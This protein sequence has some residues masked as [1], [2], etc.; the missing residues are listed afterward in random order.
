MN[1][2][3]RGLIGAVEKA[4]AREI[5]PNMRKMLFDLSEQIVDGFPFRILA[6]GTLARDPG[7]AVLFCETSDRFLCDID[8]GPD[9]RHSVFAHEDFG[10]VRS[11]F[12]LME[13]IEKKRLRAI[14]A[15]VAEGYYQSADLFG[16]IENELSS[17]P[18]TSVTLQCFQFLGRFAPDQWNGELG[19]DRAE[20]P[21]ADSGAAGK[22][23]IDMDR[24]KVEEGKSSPSDPVQEIKQTQAVLASAQGHS[25]LF[26]IFFQERK[27]E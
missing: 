12:P 18:G 25:D 11:E 9:D 4:G 13:Q 14:V 23:P 2:R 22:F 17:F 3:S 27:I 8:E 19:T 26:Y 7:K 5:A 6:N 21:C 20:V 10:Q 16:R 24:I 1:S 15:V